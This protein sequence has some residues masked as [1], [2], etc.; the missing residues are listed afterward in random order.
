M[1]RLTWVVIGLILGGGLAPA[2]AQSAEDVARRLQ[3]AWTATQAE[4]DGM[5]APD[6]VGHRLTFA[7]NR[8]QIHSKAGQA[9]YGGMFRLDPRAR[10]AAIDFAHTQGDLRGQTWKGIYLLDRDTLTICDNAGDLIKARPAALRT[11]SGSGQVLIT[12][13]RA[14]P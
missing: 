3:G 13:K 12:F 14:K 7:G 4:R 1:R 10:P 9:L 2:F 11:K 5:V 8:F 6:V